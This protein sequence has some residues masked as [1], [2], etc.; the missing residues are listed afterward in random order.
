MS[1][2]KCPLCKNSN[3]LFY[4]QDDVR[5][6]RQCQNCR[7]IFVPP[8]YYLSPEDEKKRY[9]NHE[10][11]PDDLNYRNFLTRLFKPLN[12][13]LELNSNGLDFGSGPGPTLHLMFE[14]AGHSMSNYDIFYADKPTVFEMKYDF[15][16]AAEVIEHLHHPGRELERLW[17]CLKT[18]GFLGIM[19][20]R[21]ADKEA[22]K[23]W[24]YIRDETHVAFFSDATFNWLANKWQARVSFSEDDVVIFEKKN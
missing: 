8:K 6:Y 11:E 4:H 1:K 13:K 7:L 19:T 2:T 23:A 24:H 16:S 21:A 18:G 15:I 12:E 17:N 9:D 22:F 20:K 14:E 5:S 3:T 10:N